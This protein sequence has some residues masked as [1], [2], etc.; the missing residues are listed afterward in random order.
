MGWDAT[1]LDLILMPET[2]FDA[3]RLNVMPES[4]SVFVFPYLLS[5]A[6]SQDEHVEL[7]G[8]FGER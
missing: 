1:R 7:K 2:V 6:A 5:G 3:T 4:E 8:D